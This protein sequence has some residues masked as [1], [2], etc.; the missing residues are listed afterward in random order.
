MKIELKDFQVTAARQLRQELEFARQEA[1]R[2]RPQAI[3]LS[4]PTGSGKTVTIT[5]LMEWIYD[6]YESFPADRQ[7]IFLWLSDSPELNLQ[8]RDKI[9]RQSSVF[10]EHDL[11]VVEP[12]FSQAQ[13]DAGRIYFLNTQK[14]GKDSLLTKT[15]DGRDYTIWQTIQNTATA[16]PGHFYLIIDEAHRGM[17]EKRGERDQATSI[18][19]RFIKGYPEGGLQPL[20]LVIGMSATPDRFSKL[21]EG[22][23]RTSRP[24]DI[25]PDDVKDSGLL[26]DRIILYHP[27]ES[28]PADWS[29]LEEATQR[30]RRFREAWREYC[31]SQKLESVVEPVLVVQVEDGDDRVLTRTNLDELVQVV[32]RV[33]GRLPEGAWAHAFQEDT[34]IERGGQKIRKIDA[35]KI[36][37][38]PSVQ[39]VLFKMSLT[40]GW[41]CPR[42]EV[43]MSFR[44]AKDHTLIAQLVGRMV[45]TPLARAIEGQEFLNTVSLYLPHYDDEGLRAILAKLKNPDPETGLAVGVED[46]TQLIQLERDPE[47]AKLFEKLE[48]LPTYRVERIAKTSNVRRL[49]KLARQLT[50]DEIA[51]NAWSQAKKLVV[52]TLSSELTRLSKKS[53]FVGNIAANQ[54]IE[55]RE[56]SVEYGEWK[57][58]DGAKTIKIRATAENIEDLF[59][60]AGRKLGE[61]LHS[62][63][64][65]SRRDDTDSPERGK[66]ELF[67]ILQ[68]QAAWSKLETVC[69]NKIADLFR[70]HRAAI[71]KLPSGKQEKY[72]R[73]KGNAKNPEPDTLRMPQTL[74]IRREKPDWTRHLYVDAAG[75]FGAELNSWETKV[76]EEELAKPEVVGWLRNL[77]R[78]PWALCVPYRMDGDDKPVYPDLIVFRSVD[79]EIV[80]DILDPH[81]PGNKDAVDKAKG[82]AEYAK[83]HGE[84]FGRIEIIAMDANRKLQ[85]LNLN[86]ETT[87]E[88]V[89]RMGSRSH[90]EQLLRDAR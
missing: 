34:T 65:K 58:L 28:Q 51:A 81:D 3:V 90:L 5:A 27:N 80:A 72:S 55:L 18:V 77:P 42:A 7:A 4:S 14:L 69:G 53:D 71:A 10:A 22:T 32:E 45:R 46:G 49:I 2:G 17:A 76:L 86:D 66:L 25:K 68:D 16:Q 29:L 23:G 30:W 87:R 89:S 47:K 43:M 44:R 52:K 88:D 75:N 24:V 61:G 63:F 9:M 79:G 40:T 60:D 83:K 35:S 54:E 31:Q 73:I 70:E 26:K 62:D 33:T 20:K 13:F 39:V 85:R 11:V 15:G 6:G 50:L 64:W 82:L 36:E 78:K 74:E 21:I 1:M 84:H 67:G 59:A 48:T 38:D 19:Q 56:V 12:S 37:F 8:S 41:D 57:E